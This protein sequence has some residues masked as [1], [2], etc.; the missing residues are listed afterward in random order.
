MYYKRD[1]PS[2]F[3]LTPVDLAGYDIIVDYIDT[4]S[5]TQ[6]NILKPQKDQGPDKSYSHLSTLYMKLVLFDLKAR[7]RGKSF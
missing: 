3:L 4:V 5:E 6:K 7:H 2:F 1:W